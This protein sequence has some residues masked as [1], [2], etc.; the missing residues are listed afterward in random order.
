MSLVL[1]LFTESASKRTLS[2]Y[3]PDIS[4]VSLYTILYTIFLLI[5]SHPAY[6]ESNSI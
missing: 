2:D 5:V 1:R 3:H 4:C 6:Y